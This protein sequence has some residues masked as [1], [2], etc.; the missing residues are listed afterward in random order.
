MFND[1]IQALGIM[2]RRDERRDGHGP[3]TAGRIFTILMGED[4]HG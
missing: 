4:D 2:K 3:E 1:K